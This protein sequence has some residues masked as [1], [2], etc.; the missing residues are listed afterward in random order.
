M[1]IGMGTLGKFRYHREGPEFPNHPECSLSFPLSL[2][3]PA[4][5]RDISSLCNENSLLFCPT[6]SVSSLLRF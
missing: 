6:K 4:L 5:F 1:K 3:G 2:A